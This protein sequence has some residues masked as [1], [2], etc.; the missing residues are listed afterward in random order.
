VTIGTTSTYREIKK[1][2]PPGSCLK[3]KGLRKNIDEKDPELT[4]IRDTTRK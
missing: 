4:I 1:A 2:Q 3:G